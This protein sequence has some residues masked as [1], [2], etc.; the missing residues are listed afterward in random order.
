MTRT[1]RLSMWRLTN[2]QDLTSLRTLNRRMMEVLL[3]VKLVMLPEW[4]M[5]SNAP[6]A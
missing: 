4:M 1:K 5:G 3:E 6:I 2:F